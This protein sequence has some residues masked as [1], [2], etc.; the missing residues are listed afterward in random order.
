MNAGRGTASGVDA[1]SKDKAFESYI[2]CLMLIPEVFAEGNSLL[3]PRR[4]CCVLISAHIWCKYQYFKPC[5]GCLMNN[6]MGLNDEAYNYNTVLY[7]WWGSRLR[8]TFRP[9]RIERMMA[10][11][12]V[13]PEPGSLLLTSLCSGSHQTRRHSSSPSSSDCLS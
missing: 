9:I 1:A 5:R 6:I 7:R 3:I 10:Y 8:D 2:I 11:L 12:R 13:V 4:R